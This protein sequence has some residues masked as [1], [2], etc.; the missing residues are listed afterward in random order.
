MNTTTEEQMLREL[1]SMLEKQIELVQHGNSS[2]EQIKLLGTQTD[3]LVQKITQA[4]IHKHSGYEDHWK[5]LR[6]LYDSLYLSLECQKADAANK[7]CQVRIGRKIVG[8]YRN[9]IDLQ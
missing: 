7:L 2:G 3:S 8:T 6:E 9:N 4:G 5:R 1:Q